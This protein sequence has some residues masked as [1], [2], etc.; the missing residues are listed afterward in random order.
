MFFLTAMFIK[1]F[2]MLENSQ[3]TI[4]Y[5]KRRC[6]LFLNVNEVN[7]PVCSDECFLSNLSYTRS[8]G[9][10]VFV[11]AYVRVCSSN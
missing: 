5:L 9:P 2:I 4:R 8:I 1:A 11:N 6:D 3:G 7:Y 10:D